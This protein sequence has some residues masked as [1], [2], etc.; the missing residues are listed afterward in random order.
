MN[1][2]F[3]LVITA[4]TAVEAADRHVVVA[5]AETL[6]V[7]VGGSGEP[8]VLL[9]G[10]LGGE[11]G[12]R[13][14]VP[15]LH[16]AGFRTYV[17]ELLG[18]GAS[19]RPDGADYSLERQAARVAAV[20]DSLDIWTASVIAHSIAGSVALRLALHAPDRVSGL[21]LLEAGPAESVT[22]PGLRRALKLAPLIRMLGGGNRI[23]RRIH[24][25]MVDASGDPRWVEADVVDAY[26]RA[27]AVD[28]DAMID[29]LRDM[30]ASHEPE[31]LV[32]RLGRIRQPV[33]LLL[34]GATHQGGPSTDEIFTMTA[35]LPAFEV[36]TVPGAGHFLQE[37]APQVVR[38]GA[39]RLRRA[40]L[41]MAGERSE[42]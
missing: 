40:R 26:T 39:L 23:R 32:P 21:L 15:L 33:L 4:Q 7:A 36:D 14:I 20:L 16:E 9:P 19:S 34:G 3:L 31:R 30:A 13:R 1:V 37:E 2:L 22:G 10:L 29:L 41:A 5:P 35:A 8:L 42:R 12:F 11:F 27:A 24:D 6:H 18:T 25:Q 38:D 28:A 17:V